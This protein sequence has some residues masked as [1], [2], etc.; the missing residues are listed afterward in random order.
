MSAKIVAMFDDTEARTRIRES[1]DESLLVEAAAG[2]GKTSE[3]VRRIVHVL[4]SGRARVDRIAAVTFTNKA[5]GELKLRLRAGLD[6]RLKET[7]LDG[8]GAAAE[9]LREALAHLEEASIGTLHAFCAQILRERPVEACVDPKFEELNEQQAAGLRGRAFRQWFERSL[10]ADSPALRRA[11]ARLAGAKTPA[12]EQLQHAARE[13]IEWRDYPAAWERRDWDRQADLDAAAKLVRETAPKLKR[14]KD[15]DGIRALAQW[16]E[17]FEAVRARD[18]DLLEARL[19][20][21]RKGLRRVKHVD[22]LNHGLEQ[23]RRRADADLAAALREEMLT[24]VDGYDELKRRGGKLDFL[25]LLLRARDLVRDDAGVRQYLQRRFTHL[26]VDE[27]QDTDPLQAELILLLAADDPEETDWLA[28]TPAPGK[29][30]AVGDPKQSIYKFRRADVALYQRVRSSLEE[31]G[32]RTIH[33]THNFRGTRPLEEFVNRAFAPEMTGDPGQAAY[34]PLRASRPASE[35]Q[36]SV[37]ALPVP[38]PYGFRDIAR[39]EIDASLPEAVCAFV[40][41]LVKDSGWK[42]RD[43]ERIA[44]HHVCILFRRFTNFGR[45]IARE[46]ARGLEARGVGHLLVGSRSFHQRE[47][48]ETIRAALSAI[49]WPDDELHVFATLKGS[50]FAISDADLLTW[51]AE[52]GRLHPFG[53]RSEDPALAPIGQALDL[54]AA[55]HRERNRRPA[56]ETINA[57][58]ESVRAHAAF[59]IRPAG[60]QVL[61]NVYRIADLARAY[62]TNGGIS[63]RGFV[64][65]LDRQAEKSETSESPILEEGASGVRLM[66][67]HSAKGLEFP[68]VVLADL[69]AHLNNEEPDRY[70]RGRLCATKL[71]Y[72]SPVELIEHVDEEIE[73]ERAEGVRVAYVA[74]TRARDLLVVPAVG[75]RPLGDNWLEP[76]EK[77]LYPPKNEWRNAAPAPGCPKFGE[78][79]VLERPAE[80]L[81]RPD[82]SVKPG[83]HGDVV[84]WDPAVLRLDVEPRFGI[85]H[86]NLLAPGPEAEPGIAA[87]KAWRERRERIN[88]QGARASI[89]LFLPSESTADSI[90]PGEVEIVAIP[91]AGPRPGGRRFGDLVH[92]GLRDRSPR[93]VDVAA[94]VAGATPEETHAARECVERALAH[95]LLTR[96]DAA[97][98]VLRES[99]ATLTLEDG[100]VLD[101]VIDLA[102]VEN[103][104][105]I[106]VDFKTDADL[107]AK[108]RHYAR[109]LLWYTLALTKLTGLPARGVLLSL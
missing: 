23:L 60:S 107:D 91:R 86:Q 75:D 45:D 50:L 36:P 5:A 6:R 54:L 68:V 52:A 14:A 31:R 48:V 61:A 30:F 13:L 32:V 97:T 43:G 84:W 9:H 37:V 83:L 1:L 65:A 102:F 93:A 108:R 90:E 73:R 67:V 38:R 104:E 103:G 92:A 18:Y 42:T 51:R 47:E 95:P 55:L 53:K 96:A 105:W 64:E 76:L 78:S 74:A 8:T 109:Q 20:E 25:D 21:L 106:V 24:L 44:E 59:A 94:R 46:Y 99:P 11:L 89:D 81:G 39:K 40:E 4:E 16:I 87:Y 19:L 63:F 26:F 17:R 82:E 79:S 69:T 58:L 49:E 22:A 7:S 35:T 12:S 72:L 80:W 70:V 62:E 3:L 34:V 27:F 28:A 101:G 29:L 85:Q 77:A 10:G 88:A 56:A 41:W 100:R 2:T 57:L 71:L 15:Y 98:R 33:L 66:T